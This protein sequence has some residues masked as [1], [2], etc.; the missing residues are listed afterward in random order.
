M[1]ACHYA[2]CASYTVICTHVHAC[3]AA[4]AYYTPPTAFDSHAHLL[5]GVIHA[6][7]FGHL[8]RVNGREGGSSKLTGLM[9]QAAANH[10]LQP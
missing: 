5:H 3:V 9:M 7:G 8:A 1:S 10:T 2:W 6:N 4:A